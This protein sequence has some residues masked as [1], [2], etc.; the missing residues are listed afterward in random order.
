MILSKQK[1]YGKIYEMKNTLD[2]INNRLDIA[3]QTS[4]TED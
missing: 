1:I 4:D 3:E 2:Q